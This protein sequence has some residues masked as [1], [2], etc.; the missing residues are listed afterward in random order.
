MVGGLVVGGVVV[1]A[2]STGALEG[3]LDWRA[4][5]VDCAWLLAAGY[6]LGTRLIRVTSSPWHPKVGHTLTS[7]QLFA[8]S[9]T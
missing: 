5:V 8:G 3:A 9:S 2:R 7:R 4:G 6:G 1:G